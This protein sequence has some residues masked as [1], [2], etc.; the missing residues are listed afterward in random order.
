M[1]IPKKLLEFLKQQ[2]A[3]YK[4]VAHPRTGSSMETAEQAHISGDALAKGVVVREDSEFLLVVVPSDYHIELESL[5]KMLDRDVI[6]AVE[7]ELGSLFPDCELGA[8]PPMGEPYGL[9]T[10]W[11]PNTTLGQEER[12]YFEAGDHE[13]LVSVSGRQFHELMAHA[14]RGEFSH[15]V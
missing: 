1:A 7:G 5:R 15:H 6:L 10:I 14:E 12:V 13:Y 11:D 3:N 4:L 9:T 2:D 8:V